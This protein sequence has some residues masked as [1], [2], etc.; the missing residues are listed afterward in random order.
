MHTLM[1]GWDREA[2]TDCTTCS[3]LHTDPVTHMDLVPGL[4]IPEPS[5]I[6]MNLIHVKKYIIP[7]KQSRS[8]G[9]ASCIR[10]PE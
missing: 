9:I 2:L 5:H 8:T 3:Q 4:S 7:A 6:Q 1:C 10:C